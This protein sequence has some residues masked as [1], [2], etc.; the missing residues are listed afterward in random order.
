MRIFYGNLLRS[1]NSFII[2]SVVSLLVLYSL[3]KSGDV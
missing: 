2:H 3:L 1:V